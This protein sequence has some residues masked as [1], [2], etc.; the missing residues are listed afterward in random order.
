[1]ILNYLQVILVFPYGISSSNK[2]QFV[3]IAPG[4]DYIYTVVNK[5]SVVHVSVKNWAPFPITHILPTVFNN[6]KIYDDTL[7]YSITNN[8]CTNEIILNSES[9]CT[10]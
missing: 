2:Q 1:M 4:T 3:E 7:I 10:F 5:Y 8:K 6:S 9:T